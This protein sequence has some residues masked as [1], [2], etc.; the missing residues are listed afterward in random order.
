M[1][2]VHCTFSFL[3]SPYLHESDHILRQ[4]GV[5]VGGDVPEHLNVRPH[6][7]LALLGLGDLLED[8]GDGHVLRQLLAVRALTPVDLEKDNAEGVHVALLCAATIVLA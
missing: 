5:G 7:L 3:S 6:Q 1:Y 2:T 4:V 8:L